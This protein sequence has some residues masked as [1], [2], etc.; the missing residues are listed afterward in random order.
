MDF[1]LTAKNNYRTLHFASTEESTAVQLMFHIRKLYWLYVAFDSL[2]WSSALAHETSSSWSSSRSCLVSVQ[3]YTRQT[4]LVGST[5]TCKLYHPQTWSPSGQLMNYNSYINL[6]ALN[7][8]V[9]SYRKQFQHL[10]CESVNWVQSIVQSTPESRFCSY[11][12]KKNRE[13]DHMPCDVAF[14]AFGVL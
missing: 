1:S 4:I 12:K 11:L 7:Y 13:F 8:T 2:S 9:E 6:V 14:V 3:K 5:A 10:P